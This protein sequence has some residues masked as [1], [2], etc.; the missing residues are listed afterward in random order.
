MTSLSIYTPD[1]EALLGLLD[2][3]EDSQ[4]ETLERAA[5][6]AAI[7]RHLSSLPVQHRVD[8]VCSVL[9]GLDAQRQGADTQ[10][11]R[12]RLFK[13]R[14]EHAADQLK[15]QLALAMSTLGVK[16]IA[17]S[18]E[19]LV[20]KDNPEAVQFSDVTL[21]PD[22]Y[23]TINI[24]MTLDRWN[25]I[26]QL[27]ADTG[28]DK[29]LDSVTTDTPAPQKA[30]IRTVLKGGGGVPGAFLDRGVTVVRR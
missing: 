10:L 25:D 1:D 13:A 23:H 17:G 20:L 18:A 21:V 7:A 16:R 22:E 5:A 30:L 9:A 14:V 15:N 29:M 19:S 6:D 4:P 3:Y 26:C 27:L 8:R 2:A 12:L 11:M 24:K 28:N